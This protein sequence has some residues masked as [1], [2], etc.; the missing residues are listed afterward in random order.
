ME[1]SYPIANSEV[2]RGFTY[3]KNNNTV[4]GKYTND[5]EELRGLRFFQTPLQLQLGTSSSKGINSHSM[6]TSQ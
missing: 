5:R 3:V 6:E 4:Q 2:N 1:G